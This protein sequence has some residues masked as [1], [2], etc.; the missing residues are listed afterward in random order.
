MF[1]KV[2]ELI[3]KLNYNP[4]KQALK[5]KRI[6][7][8]ENVI[9]RKSTKFTINGLNSS[10]KLH[11]GS[12]VS[13]NLIIEKDCASISIGENT[14]INDSTS[15]IASNRIDIGNNVTIAWGCLIYDHNSHSTNILDRMEDIQLQREALQKGLPLTFNK[16][17]AS[18]KSSPIV[19][20]N[21][22]WIG[23]G[24]T[25]LQGVRIGAGAII[26]AGSVVRQN[27]PP[28]S[29]V[30]GNPAQIVKTL[31]QIN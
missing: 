9:I 7:V 15:L 10:I 22:V 18:V 25:I 4:Q 14:F 3:N 27:V 20:E 1:K 12:I 28:M 19:I 5:E 6:V 2:Q 21:D 16:K 23:Y 29:V 26:G 8:E 11:K 13:C 24:C 17:W 30:I 31:K